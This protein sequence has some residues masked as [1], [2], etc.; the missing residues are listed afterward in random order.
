MGHSR[1]QQT[2]TQSQAYNNTNTVGWTAPPDT[3]D[4]EALR[5]MQFTADPRIPYAF[6][7]ER[8]HAQDSYA[9][10]LGG[11]STPQLQQAALNAHNQDS[12]QMESQAHAEDEHARQ[13]MEFGKRSTVAGLTAPRLYNSGSSGTNSGTGTSTSTYS[14]SPMDNV[15]KGASAAGSLIML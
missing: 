1:Q 7:H 11:Y 8:Q 12:A 3:A 9:N 5:Q 14:D 6:A 10:T 4:I 2:Q 13:A 15:V